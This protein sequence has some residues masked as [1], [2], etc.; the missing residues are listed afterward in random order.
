MQYSRYGIQFEGDET[1]DGERLFLAWN[2]PV[3]LLGL[4]SCLGEGSGV[5]IE[6][7]HDG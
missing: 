1:F 5:G 7:A 2:L 6:I 4:V 3:A